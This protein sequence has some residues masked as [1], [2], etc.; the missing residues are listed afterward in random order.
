MRKEIQ[1]K[2]KFNLIFLNI[3]LIIIFMIVE[4]VI[5]KAGTQYEP[6]TEA[7][8][9]AKDIKEKT[10]ITEDMLEVKKI[11]INLVNK[12][13]I[14]NK[15]DILNK[16]AAYDI[17][18]GEMILSNKVR[19]KEDIYNINIDSNKRIFCLELKPDQASGWMIKAGQT[20]D[21]IYI[22]N[23]LTEKDLS[24]IP[25]PLTHAKSESNDEGKYYYSNGMVKKLPDIKI[26]ALIDD[27]GKLVENS[28]TTIPKYICLEVTQSQDEFLAY[29]KSNGRLEL[30]AI[31]EDIG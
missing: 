6:V 19:A 3:I 21:I 28:N 11:N 26:V 18:K 10:V 9:A 16:K 31:P 30:S 17:V 2:N 13:T 5:I 20:V 1:V 7:V 12:N 25:D 22:P 23:N 15:K 27:K 4:I 8:F 14:K 29:C 24:Q